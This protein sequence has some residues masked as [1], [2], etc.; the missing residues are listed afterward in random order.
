MKK[1][2]MFKEKFLIFL[3]TQQ[4][5]LDLSL[6]QKMLGKLELKIEEVNFLMKNMKSF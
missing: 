6:K 3:Y 1:E 2:Q 5:P 4:L